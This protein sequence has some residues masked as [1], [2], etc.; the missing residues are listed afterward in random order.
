MIYFKEGDHSVG[1]LVKALDSEPKG[2]RIGG[3]LVSYGSPSERDLDGEYFTS[4]T[5]FYGVKSLPLVYQHGGNKTLKGP[6][7]HIGEL[8]ISYKDAG[9]WAE[10]EIKKADEFG[11]KILDLVKANKLRWSSGAAPHL[12]YSNAGHVKAWLMA[13]GSVAPAVKDFR[14]AVV[15]LK[16]LLGDDDDESYTISRQTIRDL[17]GVGDFLKAG[18]VLS[19]ANRELLTRLRDELRRATG[20]LETLLAATIPDAEANPFDLDFQTLTALAVARAK[21]S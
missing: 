18:R 14:N 15:P 9:V 4:D 7:S 21:N 3:Y 20:D 5:Y 16:A 17:G 2:R 19:T 11:D 1:G 13:E 8:A 10:G 12:S 6:T